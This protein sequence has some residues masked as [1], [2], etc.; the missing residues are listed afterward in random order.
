MRRA[1]AASGVSAA[2]V[3]QPVPELSHW[4][5]PRRRTHSEHGTQSQSSVQNN[6]QPVLM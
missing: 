6:G 4:L 1:A 3:G 5:Q 2:H